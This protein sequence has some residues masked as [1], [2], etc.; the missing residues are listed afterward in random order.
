VDVRI[1]QWRGQQAARR[2]Q[3]AVVATGSRAGGDDPSDAIALC[4]DVDE[5]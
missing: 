1:D 4:E 3:L 2:V 5:A